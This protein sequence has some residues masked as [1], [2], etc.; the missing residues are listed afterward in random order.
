M[1]V[2]YC[3]QLTDSSGYGSAA[4]GYLQAIDA[5]LLDNPDAFD[6]R[7]YNIAFEGSS[8]ISDKNKE[9]IKKYSFKS[10]EDLNEFIQDDYVASWHLPAPSLL[11]HLHRH[12][13][14]VA[15]VTEA[16][17]R[18]ASR[19]VNLAAWEYSKV[20]L[21]WK[22]VYKDY[23]FD[24]IITPS[25]WN[26]DVFSEYCQDMDV[27]LLPHV[28]EPPK[29]EPKEPKLINIKNIED[30]FV[31][32]SMSQWGFRKGF[33]IL[34]RAFC[35]EF[36]KED[37]V[38]LVLKT[39]GHM[40]GN[41]YPLEEK[42]Q[43]EKIREEISNIKRSVLYDSY[44]SPSAPIYFIPYVLPFENI[45][46]LHENSSLF[47]LPTRGE[48]FGLTIAEALVHKR[49]VLVP[50]VG[51]H[52]DYIN[53]DSA[54]YVN[55]H[56]EPSYGDIVHTCDSYWYE[57]HIVSVREQLRKAY[58]MWKEDRESLRLKGEDGCTHILEN[59][60]DSHS[61]ASEFNSIVIAEH[62]KIKDLKKSKATNIKKKANTLK[63]A[64]K[65]LNTQKKKVDFLKDQFKGEE[66]YLLSCGPSLRDYDPDYLREILKDKLVIAVKQAYDYVPDCVDFHLWNCSNLPL[67]NH[68]GNHY[69]Y[70][71]KEPITICSSN[72]DLGARW[73]A[74]NQHHDLFFKI[75]IRTEINNEFL[76]ITKK[77]DDYLLEKSLTRPCGPGIMYETAI[78]TAVHLGVSKITALGWDLSKENP[79]DIKGAVSYSDEY[80]HFYEGSTEVFNRGDVLPWEVK[81]TCEASEDL[82]KWLKSR[83]I[84][85]ELASS[86]SALSDIIPR[87]EL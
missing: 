52:M 67:P 21:E 78:Y 2:I 60:Y 40:M 83:N 77:F 27:Y 18:K 20:P 48:G 58:D 19:V 76:T 45:S 73:D 23:N 49:P 22:K 44:K 33:D 15:N 63:W 7:V 25:S 28:I 24:S 36:Q 62:E 31:V 34:I 50:D 86:R 66:C 85:L 29:V 5:F 6:L 84:E 82:Y 10:S 54:F 14:K 87:R 12:D 69:P 57:P 32:F 16:I 81:V 68:E 26:K 43:N 65:T 70:W 17:I 80:P 79:K 71:E 39:Y 46:W 53:P 35:S 41:V 51:G 72:Y 47:A 61:I 30:K 13:K 56:W 64:M 9:I 11:V 4:R 55:G 1:K 74:S 75:P 42:A 59:G 37:D 3:G 8:K 38:A